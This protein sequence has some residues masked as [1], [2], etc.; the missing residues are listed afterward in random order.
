M[1]GCSSATRRVHR[2]ADRRRPSSALVTALW[3]LEQSI[4]R[5]RATARRWRSTIAGF[6]RVSEQERVFAGAAG[7]PCRSAH[8][9]DYALRDLDRARRLRDELTAV[10]ADQARATGVA[11]SALPWLAA[12]TVNDTR[13]RARLRR[14]ASRPTRSSST[15][16]SRL[17]VVRIAPGY[18]R[19]AGQWTLPG[20]GL[21][22]GEDPDRCG[23]SAS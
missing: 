12:G 10:L 18:T 14:R 23:A 15:T 11:R 16:A 21:N 19:D 20:G 13:Q 4:G 6:D 1:V 17:L 8:V 22:F 2:S 7:L 5:C 9:L 3:R